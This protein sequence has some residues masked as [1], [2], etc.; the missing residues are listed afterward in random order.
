MPGG[1]GARASSGDPRER[2]R[3][4]SHHTETVLSTA[5]ARRSAW[6][7]RPACRCPSGAGLELALAHGAGHE[8]VRLDVASLVEPYRSSGLPARTMGRSLDEDRDF[9][10]AGLAGGGAAG[11]MIGERSRLR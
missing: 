6:R 7:C 5:A 10:L 11:D 9:F 4:L 8:A 2:H 3:G 1:A